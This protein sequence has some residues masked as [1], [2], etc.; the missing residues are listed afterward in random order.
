VLSDNKIGICA[1]YNDISKRVYEEE[2]IKYLSTHD[3]LTGIY[4]RNYYQIEIERLSKSRKLPISIIIA[5]IDRLKYVN[6]NYGHIEGDNYIKI[7]VSIIK[8][9]L[10]GEDIFARIGGD[11]FA[12]ILMETSYEESEMIVGRINEEINQINDEFEYKVGVSMGIA[13]EK[14]KRKSLNDLVVEA[15][16]KMYLNK[17]KNRSKE[18]M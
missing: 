17:S 11:E 15:D 9:V 5:D 6:D 14:I 18:V 13:T 10:R 1:I 8:N 4:N 3:Q 16:N 2:K 12:I 7:V